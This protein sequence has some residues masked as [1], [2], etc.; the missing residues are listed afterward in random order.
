MYCATFWGFDAPNLQSIFG[1]NLAPYSNAM[2]YIFFFGFILSA[3]F[4]FTSLPLH[5][6]AQGTCS[7]F[8][9]ILDLSPNSA[10]SGDQVTV[11]I[12]GLSNCQNQTI[13]FTTATSASLGQCS[14]SSSGQGCVH[15]ITAPDSSTTVFARL[16]SNPNNFD[17]RP[18]TIIGDGGGGSTCSV[19]GTGQTADVGETR[20]DACGAGQCTGTRT[21]ACEAG[22][23]WGSPS[24]CSS[25]GKSCDGGSGTCDATGLCVATTPGGGVA[26]TDPAAGTTVAG[27]V[28]FSATALAGTARV[29]FLV[30]GAIKENDTSSPYS[31]QWDTTNAGAHPCDGAHT[32]ALEARAY[33]PAGA[34]LGTSPTITV[35]MND[36]PYCAGQEGGN[37][38]GNQGGGDPIEQ[39]PEFG[40]TEFFNILDRIAGFIFTAALM[41][42][43]LM[44]LIGAVLLVTGGGE[45]ARLLKARQAFLWIFVGLVVVLIASGIPLVVRDLIE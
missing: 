39:V 11:T 15:I 31:F 21:F 37:Q 12:G 29:E 44:I 18:L 26:I 20:Q 45:S 43:V 27:T 13:S 22:G 33:G 17:S 6:E 32:H 8:V 40:R 41:I 1:R 28:T 10:Y 19:P 5:A 30:D 4:F 2:K 24:A 7:G 16:D 23:T 14:V 36:P 35:N 9:S 38:G 25:Q 34:L 3:V 42:A